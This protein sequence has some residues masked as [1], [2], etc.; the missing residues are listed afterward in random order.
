[1]HSLKERKGNN[2]GGGGTGDEPLKTTRRQ[3]RSKRPRELISDGHKVAD[4]RV[5]GG[6]CAAALEKK[7][8]ER[9]KIQAHFAAIVALWASTDD[10]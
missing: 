6:T 10:R 3:T 2:R 1:M 7:I 4:L 5:G 8:L 9:S